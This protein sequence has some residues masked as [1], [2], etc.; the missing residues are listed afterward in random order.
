MIALSL[1][2]DQVSSQRHCAYA[3]DN[4]SSD[5]KRRGREIGTGF[6]KPCL[7]ILPSVF[8]VEWECEESIGSTHGK[9]RLGGHVAGG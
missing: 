4:A 3:E 8:T 5:K 6:G 2:Y 9:A 1:G 7:F